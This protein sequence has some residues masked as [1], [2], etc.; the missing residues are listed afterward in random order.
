V[1]VADAQVLGFPKHARGWI[2][3]SFALHELRLTKEARDQLLPAVT[4]FTKET[5]I[6]Y[7]LACY[8]CQL[9]NLE[10][11]RDWLHQALDRHKS[12]D[13]RREQLAMALA[14]PDL[15]P[16][17]SEIQRGDFAE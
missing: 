1:A 3:R 4:M 14:D 10:A 7:N 2:H 13:G 17:A 8:E 5:T 16:L 15:L 6:P 9:G 12:A 11:A